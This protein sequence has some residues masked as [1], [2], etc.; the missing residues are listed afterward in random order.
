M[1]ARRLLLSSALAALLAS[2]LSAAP[3]IP[4]YIN[5]QGY[6]TNAAGVA[7]ADANYDILF[8]IYNSAGTVVWGEKQTVTVK[9]GQFSILLGNGGLINGG[10]PHGALENLFGTDPAVT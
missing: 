4:K 3:A 5:Y 10:T 8:K 2:P 1:K 7:L 6:V 9:D